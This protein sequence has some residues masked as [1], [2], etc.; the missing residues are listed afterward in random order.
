[1]IWIIIGIVYII[2]LVLIFKNLRGES[3]FTK[4]DNSVAFWVTFL[5]FIPIVNLI[6]LI[7]I[8]DWYKIANKIF[9]LKE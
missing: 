2:T 6:I 4:N 7:A 1:M 5:I 8:T 3:A 9:R